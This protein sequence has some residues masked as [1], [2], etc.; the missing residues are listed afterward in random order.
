MPIALFVYCLWNCSTYC[1]LYSRIEEIRLV[2]FWLKKK[3]CYLM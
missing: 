2:M 1:N 3:R